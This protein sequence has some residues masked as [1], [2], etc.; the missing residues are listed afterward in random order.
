MSEAGKSCGR[1]YSN[2]ELVRRLLAL[3]WQFRTDCLLSFG[4]SVILLLL[5]LAGLQFLGTAIDVIRHALS[6]TQRAPIYPFGWTPP[7]HWQPF[8]VV[9]ALS[10]AIVG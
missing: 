10:L 4:L 8:D 7:G 1:H 9:F 3:A 2:G 5:G 6:E